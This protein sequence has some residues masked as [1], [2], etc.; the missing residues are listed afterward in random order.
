LAASSGSIPWACVGLVAF[1]IIVLIRLVSLRLTG[2][3]SSKEE[4]KTM[5][6]KTH[7]LGLFGL[8]VFE[9]TWAITTAY[10]A[11]ALPA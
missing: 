2:T 5:E 8:S 1:S 3:T 7:L 10:A 11:G 6:G 9:S 4:A